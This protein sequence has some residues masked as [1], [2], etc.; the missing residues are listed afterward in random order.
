MKIQNK[1]PLLKTN[2]KIIIPVT[3]ILILSLTALLSSNINPKGQIQFTGIVSKQI[4][5]I[6]I[7]F[8]TYFVVSR[9]NYKYYKFLQITIPLH[10]IV[11][12]LLILTLQFGPT[13][14][15]AQRWLPLLG[16]QIQPSELAKITTILLTA[17]IM[18]LNKNKWLLASLSLIPVLITVFLIYIQPH[19]SMAL[20]ILT[21]WGIVVFT[22]FEHQIRNGLILLLFTSLGFGLLNLNYSQDLGLV[23][24][25][26]L[27]NHQKERIE[28]FFNPKDSQ[29][30]GFNVEQSQVAIGSGQFFG[31]GF[32]QGTQSKLNFLPEHQTDFLFTSFAEEFGLI[33]T[34]LLTGLYFVL[35]IVLFSINFNLNDNFAC[36]LVTVFSFKILMEV[37][38]NIGTN[39]GIIPATGIPLPLFSAGGS[40]TITTFLTLGILENINNNEYK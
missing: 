10:I 19:G 27:Y 20:I 7:G 6:A 25:L 38:I 9:I 26:P 11:I 3:L 35:I 13:V 8:L 24:K 2:L 28:H 22:T 39:T 36:L 30:I 16:F 14:K 4:I 37:F 1:S 31:K 32:G 15:S 5:F 33:G 29:D 21:L 34:F 18:S 12:S 40:I 17:S 23:D